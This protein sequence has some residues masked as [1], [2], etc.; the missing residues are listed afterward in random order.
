MKKDKNRFSITFLKRRKYFILIYNSILFQRKWY[1][2]IVVDC[3]YMLFIEV[4][5]LHELS[6]KKYRTLA[7]I[8]KYVL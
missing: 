6:V 4:E 1:T 3:T 8:F 5:Y 2:I 7:S